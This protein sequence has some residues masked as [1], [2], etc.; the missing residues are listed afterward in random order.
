MLSKTQSRT[1]AWYEKWLFSKWPKNQKKY[2]TFSKKRSSE[3]EF[4]FFDN[5]LSYKTRTS[6][7]IAFRLLGT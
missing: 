2:E 1:E 3:V 5:K 6:P 7:F 4:D